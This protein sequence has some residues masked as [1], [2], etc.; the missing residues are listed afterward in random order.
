MKMATPQEGPEEET[1]VQTKRR[2]TNEEIIKRLQGFINI[3]Q[4]RINGYEADIQRNPE[5]KS[6]YGAVIIKERAR[7]ERLQQDILDL[8]FEGL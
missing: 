3:T 1:F 2:K 6:D 4:R 7:I 5:L 8:Q